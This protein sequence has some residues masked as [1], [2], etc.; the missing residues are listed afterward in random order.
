MT[1][2]KELVLEEYLKLPPP[3]KKRRIKGMT[4]DQWNKLIGGAKQPIHNENI[5]QNGIPK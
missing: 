4:A 2:E 1:K 5:K 3:R